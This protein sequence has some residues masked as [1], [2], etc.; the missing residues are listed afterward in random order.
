[1]RQIEKGGQN[2]VPALEAI[3]E[4]KRFVTD[5]DLQEAEKARRAAK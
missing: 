3:V 5:K 1:M 4:T 2:A